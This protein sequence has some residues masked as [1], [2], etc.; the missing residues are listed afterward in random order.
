MSKIIKR[1]SASLEDDDPPYEELE[2][3][4][5]PVAAKRAPLVAMS[6]PPSGA[7]SLDNLEACRGASPLGHS[8]QPS[9]DNSFNLSYFSKARYE[10]GREESLVEEDEDM[11]GVWIRRLVGKCVKNEP[12]LGK[13]NVQCRKICPDT[14]PSI[15]SSRSKLGLC[16]FDKV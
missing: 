5:T 14:I 12:I 13:M 8:Y 9:C 2:S 6:F 4:P 15:M 10:V 16:Y 11:P 3:A 7:S 1:L